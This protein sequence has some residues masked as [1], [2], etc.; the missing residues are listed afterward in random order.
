MAAERRRKNW[1]RKTRKTRKYWPSP[2]ASPPPSPRS[3]RRTPGPRQDC[4]EVGPLGEQ[5]R[6]AGAV[7]SHQKHEGSKAHQGPLRLRLSAL[8]PF[9]VLV[10]LVLAKRCLRRS[11]AGRLS[12]PPT[13]SCLGPDFRRD[14]REVGNDRPRSK[15]NMRT[16][17]PYPASR[18]RTGYRIA[19]A[20][21]FDGNVLLSPHSK[22]ENRALPGRERAVNL[23]LTWPAA[24]FP[25]APGPYP[26]RAWHSYVPTASLA[27]LSRAPS[28][29]NPNNG[30]SSAWRPRPRPPRRG[31]SEDQGR[32]HHPR[33]RQ[34]KAAGRRSHRRRPRRPRRRRQDRIRST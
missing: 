19:G 21:P 8:A 9:A 25:R 17:A 16:G 30:V 2:A 5:V 28:S 10:L 12:R 6:A 7:K 26:K 33:H 31:R 29:E 34:G 18:R 14:E 11:H 4:G 20:R 27:A 1:P 13:P 15:G 22:R 3:S 24:L 32:D 23:R